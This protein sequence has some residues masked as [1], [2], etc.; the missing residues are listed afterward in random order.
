MK[1]TKEKVA[2]HIMNQTTIVEPFDETKKYAMAF[3]YNDGN[4]IVF[5]DIRKEELKKW[6]A[7]DKYGDYNTNFE[8]LENE[9][10]MKICQELANKYN[11][12]YEN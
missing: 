6:G 4:N 9:N 5:K 7:F 1:I 8:S 3:C 2:K 10:F 11:S 12:E